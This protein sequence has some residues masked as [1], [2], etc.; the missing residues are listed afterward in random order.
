MTPKPPIPRPFPRIPRPKPERLSKGRLVTI[1]ASVLCTDG[2]ILC[3][4][5]EETVS[6]DFKGSKS[7]ILV[8]H[9]G[10]NR[11]KLWISSSRVG[12][13]SREGPWAMRADWLVG[14]AG[15]GHSDWIRAFI[16]GMDRNV[17]EQLFGKKIDLEKLEEHLRTYSQDY[18]QRF[19]KSYADDPSHRPQVHI[20]VAAQSRGKLYRSIFRVNDNVVLEERLDNFESIG[21]GAPAFDH[22]AKKLLRGYRPMKQ[23]ASIVIYILKRVRAQVPGCGGNSHVALLGTNG[24]LEVLTT[25]RVSELELHQVE[26]E[27]KSYND[28]AAELVKEIP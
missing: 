1:A 11:R 28:L 7:K 10:S 5:T 18:F 19:I 20:L 4:D 2:I 13:S 21:K 16:E 27:S 3:A 15:A 12:D 9:H 26:L 6:D 14:I 25:R 17:F 22:L 23:T 24:K 8:V